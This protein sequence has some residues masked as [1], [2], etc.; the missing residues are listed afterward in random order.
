MS[1]NGTLKIFGPI[2]EETTA[3]Q[4]NFTMRSFKICSLLLPTYTIRVI[5]LR[6]MRR[7]GHV[8]RMI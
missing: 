4:E 3:D 2:R 5:K 1:E 6:S 8:A 7:A